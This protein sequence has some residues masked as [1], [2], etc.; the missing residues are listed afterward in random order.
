MQYD[1]IVHSYTMC[2]ILVPKS[3]ISGQCESDDN[4]LDQN[5]E[6]LQN[7]CTC[8]SGYVPSNNI[9]SKYMYIN[10][11]CAKMCLFYATCRNL[12]YNIIFLNILGS[13]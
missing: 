1:I 12:Y 8:G 4:C 3:Q 7:I 11:D 2:H 6:C 5:A 9:C 13:S 10:V